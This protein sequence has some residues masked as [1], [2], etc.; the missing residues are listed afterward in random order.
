MK[1]IVNLLSVS[2]ILCLGLVS[3][4]EDE[5]TFKALD[6]PVDAFVSLESTSASV[7]E[8][9]GSTIDIVM[10]L[11]TSVAAT[12]TATTVGFTIASDNAREGVH[13]TVV[14]NKS[15]FELAAGVFSDT[16][17]IVPI[18]N[19]DEDGDKVI[20][21]ILNNAPVNLGFPGPDGLG[22]TMT[23]TL[24]DDD[25]A[26]SLADLGAATWIGED[27]VP[28]DEAGPNDTMIETSFDGTDLLME[29]LSYAW[30][31]DTG[32][33]NEVVVVSHKVIVNVDL[34]TGAI[35]IARQPLCTAT[36]NGDIQPNYEISGSGVY[37]S[38]SE[39]MVINY[40][41]HQDNASGPDMIR[42]QYTETITKN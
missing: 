14:N 42:R 9:S 38:C 10:N 34:I 26:F 22:K 1:K 23:I 35:T 41:L 17:Q 12:T 5:T 11:S 28:G 16:L 31:T 36:W 40:T 15:S 18:D 13:Y 6:Y 39:T 33:W 24:Q 19:T 8:S 21:I 20:T 2:L 29:G 7:L 25:C 3:C 32:Y 30:I 27:N 4:D 37:T